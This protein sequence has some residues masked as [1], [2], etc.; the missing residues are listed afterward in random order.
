M[1]ITTKK[2]YVTYVLVTINVIVFGIMTLIGGTTNIANLLRFGASFQPYI[3]AGQWYRL[4]TPMFIHIGFEHLFLNMLTLYF[5][6]IFLEQLFGWWRFTLIYFIA[7][8]GGNLLSAALAP[9]T[10][11]A[12]AS[13]AIFGMFGAFVMLGLVYRESEYFQ[14]LGRQ[15]GILIILNLA[16]AF[17]PG[18]GIDILGHIGGLIAGFLAALMVGTPAVFGPNKRPY[19]LM[20]L[21]GLIIYTIA[22]SWWLING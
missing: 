17:W 3:L 5:C 10:V 11:S 15:F 21:A 12:G 16:F 19:Q 8:I 1:Q 2:P 14:A 9:T 6:G 7:G 20:G 13:T 18:T 4:V 22:T